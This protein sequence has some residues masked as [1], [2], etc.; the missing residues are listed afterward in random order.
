MKKGVVS[1][2]RARVVFEIKWKNLRVFDLVAFSTSN[3]KVKIRFLRHWHKFGALYGYPNYEFLE[4]VL[5][6]ILFV[7]GRP[8]STNP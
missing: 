6:P 7:P 5:K 8:N 2:V 4:T 1:G 3:E